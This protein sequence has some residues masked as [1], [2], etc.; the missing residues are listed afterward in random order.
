MNMYVEIMISGYMLLMLFFFKYLNKRIRKKQ[1][2]DS[3]L[4]VLTEI[5]KTPAVKFS[6]EL[7]DSIGFRINYLFYQILFLSA[8]VYHE[9]Y[10]IAAVAFLFATVLCYQAR[11][12]ASDTNLNEI[13]N[14]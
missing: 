2:S 6:H 12:L 13:S 10:L 5:Y 7:V 1:V 9:L 4:G 14:S 8:L 11:R 3:Y